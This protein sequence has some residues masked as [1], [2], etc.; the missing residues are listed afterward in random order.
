MN[1]ALKILEKRA[2]GKLRKDK[3]N[4]NSDVTLSLIELPWFRI[5]TTSITES[6]P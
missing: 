5:L 1:V 3:R 4:T 6:V 2:L